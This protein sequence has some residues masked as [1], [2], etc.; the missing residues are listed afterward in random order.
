MNTRHLSALVLACAAVLASSPA[1]AQLRRIT[2]VPQPVR[3][4][5]PPGVAT[6][7]TRS[8]ETVTLPILLVGPTGT[9]KELFAHHIHERSGQP[10]PL[11]EVNCCALPRD[12]VESLLFG[13]RRGAFTGAIESTVGYV[14]RSDGGTLFLDELESLAFEAQGKLARTPPSTSHARSSRPTSTTTACCR[15]P[16]RSGSPS[17]CPRVSTSSIATTTECCRASNTRTRSNDPC[18]R[19]AARMRRCLR[20]RCAR[21]DARDAGRRAAGDPRACH[22]AAAA[23][24]LDAGAGPRSLSTG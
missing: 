10:G 11:V 22:A 5:P 6:L 7:P 14:E 20:E 4:A 17:S 18:A 23:E 15:A 16:R 1:I 9:G 19:C 2:P 8:K 21:A 12:M 24:P 3:Q 13:H